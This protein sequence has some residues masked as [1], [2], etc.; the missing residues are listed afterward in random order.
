MATHAGRGRIAF[1]LTAVATLALIASADARVTRIEITSKT[2]PL[3]NGQSFGT[4]G[5]YEQIRGFAYGEIDPA[6]RHNNVITDINLAPRNAGGKVEYK[7]TFTIVKPVDMSKAPPV[8][9]YNVA[10]RGN[11]SLPNA[12]LFGNDPGDGFIYKLGHTMV[13]SGWQGDQPIA[14][15]A[16][17]QEGIDVPIAKNADGSP[18]T[19]PVWMRFANGC[20]DCIAIPTAT[21]RATTLSLAPG[22]GRTAASTDNTNS[23]LISATAETQSGVKGGVVTIP[24]SDYAFA[25]CRTVAFPGTP[26][27]TRLCL[28]NG[29]DPTLLYELTYTAKDPFVLGVGMAAMRDVIS[30]LRYQQKDDQGNANPLA[31]NIKWVLGSGH[32]QSGRFQKNYVNL[33]FNE[34]ESGKIIW[35]GMWPERAGQSGQF[36]I[37]FAQPG[38]IADLFEPGGEQ[39]TWWPDVV[40]TA[41]GRPAWGIL[42]RCTQTNT[43]PKVTETYGGPEVWYSRGSTGISGTSGRTDIPVPDNVRRYYFA[44]TTHGGG[45]GGFA[46]D[47]PA[48]A[49]AMLASNPNPNTEF[50]RAIYVAL[51]DWVTKGIAP[52]PSVY[53]TIADGTLVAANDTALGYPKIPRLPTTNGVM[54]SMLDYD[55]GTS[56]N[57]LDNS[58]VITVT[59][60]RVKQVIP[61]LAVKVNQD[62]NEVAGLRSVL[63]RNPLGTYTG[64]NPI[65]SGI[66]RGQEQNLAG[67]YLPFAKTKAARTC[68]VYTATLSGANET[69]PNGSTQTGTFTLLLG[70]DNSISCTGTTSFTP[71]TITASHIHQAA[72]GVAGPI[73]VPF[74]V[75]GNIVDCSAGAKLTDDQVTALNSGGLYANVHSAAFPGGEIRGQLVPGNPATVTDPRL[76]IEERYPN[77]WGYYY[78]AVQSANELVA[79]RYLLPEDAQRTINTLLN[80]MLKTGLLPKRGEFMPG[81]APKPR[82]VAPPNL[83]EE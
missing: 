65:A 14:S 31:G 40:D 49:G 43:C 73:I 24:K 55:Y 33:G 70:T 47:Q 2:S 44:G 20:R 19:G 18:V 82:V 36:N 77:L 27:P 30:F 51:T 35:D 9:L 4:I 50:F 75:S 32:S 69:P 23:T 3:F 83:E 68:K 57:Y 79:Q 41:R 46:L 48:R 80:D 26:D 6:D 74:T 7:T 58:G 13:W 54:N 67:G 11:H 1:A 10:N 62:G 5:A 81:F 37:R 38:N 56:F 25:D 78:N 42:H 71:G 61:T 34:D 76:S 29:F 63:L 16:A 28:K 72:S 39:P 8:M 45:G 12:F 15:V 66:F 52:P 64:W 17:G 21:P 53:P 59:P 60:P 22:P